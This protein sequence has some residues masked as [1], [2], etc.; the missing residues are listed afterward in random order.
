MATSL[1]AD[2]LRLLS[3]GTPCARLLGLLPRRRPPGPRSGVLLRPCRGVHTAGMAY[4]IQ[5]AFIDRNG[6]V[7]R[8]RTLAPWRAA[9]CRGAV[10]VVETRAGVIAAEDGGIGR[11]EAAVQH[12]ARR[13]VHRHLQRIHQRRG[14]AGRHQ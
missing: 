10:A 3:L 8:V 14:Q 6:R 4:A 13:D 5:V 9:L 11:I 12:A 7:L 2:R 1:P